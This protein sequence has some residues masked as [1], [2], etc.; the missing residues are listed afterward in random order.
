MKILVTANKVPFMTGGA[1][2]HIRGLIAQL[3]KQGHQV[4][5]IR[6]PF[7]FQPESDIKQLMHYC[8]QLD[9]NAP[10]GIKIDKLIS[11]QFPAYG[12]QHDNHSVW[13]M[14]QQRSAYELFKAE[15]AGQAEKEFRRQVIDY[16]NRVLSRVKNRFANSVTVAQRLQSNNQLSS[17]PLYHPPFAEQ[18]FFHAESQNYIFC[19]SRLERLKR[20]D[21]L[22]EAARHLTTP[23]KI[24]IAGDGGQKNYYQQLIEKYQLADSISLLGHISE[25]EKL[26]FYANS[27]AVFFAPY[28]EDYGYITLESQ[29]SAKPVITCNDSGGPLE[30]IEDQ[31]NGYICEPDPL[32]IAALIDKLYN[33]PQTAREMGQYGLQSYKNKNISWENVIHQ[34]V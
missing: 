30:F 20:Q 31:Q 29:L 10:N 25:T 34:L 8:Q 23:V 1:E 28:D 12:V 33:H 4:E 6:F 7:R 2:Y 11:L 26:T 18:Q 27:L 17:V 9:F 22:I 3:Q 21:L 32:Q 19:P 5:S 24:L 15:Q 14:H 16:D 13:L